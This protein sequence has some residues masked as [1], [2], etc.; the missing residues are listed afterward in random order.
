MSICTFCAVNLIN[1]VR[2][3]ERLKELSNEVVSFVLAG[4]A[5][6]KKVIF[7]AVDVEYWNM[8]SESVYAFL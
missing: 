1:F 3:C 2:F 6:Y 8:E 4:I 5:C 7:D